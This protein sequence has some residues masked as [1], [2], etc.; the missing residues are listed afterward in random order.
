MLV[1]LAGGALAGRVVVRRLSAPTWL[2]ACREA[3]MVGPCA[4]AVTALAGWLSGGPAGGNR[5]TDVGPSPWRLGL[6]VTAEV[7]VGAAAAAAMS[8]RRLRP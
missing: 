2:V 8:V 7:A 5:L 6:A 4:G 3:A 1:P